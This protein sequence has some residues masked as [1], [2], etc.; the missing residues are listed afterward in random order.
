MSDNKQTAAQP[1]K[2]INKD[3]KI[4][5]LKLYN[6]ILCVDNRW[7]TVLKYTVKEQID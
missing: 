5:N 1:F 6:T 7:K 2:K 4:I 3:D